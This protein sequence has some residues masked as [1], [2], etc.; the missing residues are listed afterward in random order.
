MEV[1]SLRSAIQ[2][3]PE[4]F[5]PLFVAPESCSPEAVLDVV[6]FQEGFAEDP[7][8]L[9]IAGYFRSCVQGLEEDGELCV[10]T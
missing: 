5:E 6:T 1:F 8:K 10:Y 3:F 7:A 9:R 2:A 4:S